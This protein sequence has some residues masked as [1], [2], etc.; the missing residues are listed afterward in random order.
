MMRFHKPKSGR[1]KKPPG[2]V[3]SRRTDQRAWVFKGSRVPL[4]ALFEALADG[5]SFGEF[6]KR[7]PD[8]QAEEIK[9]VLR[10]VGLLVDY[11][12]HEHSL[13]LKVVELEALKGPSAA[14]TAVEQSSGIGKEL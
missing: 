5:E 13:T 12:L 14:V 3:V 4:C 10:G 8:L 7:I 9:N 6:V 11:Q 2:K 1:V